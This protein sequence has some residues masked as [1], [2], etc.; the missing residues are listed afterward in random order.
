MPQPVVVKHWAA[1]HAN[2]RFR[3]FSRSLLED[4]ASS[5]ADGLASFLRHRW[6]DFGKV[7]SMP[8]E[9]FISMVQNWDI[10]ITFDTLQ[11]MSQ[12]EESPL[13]NLI[14]NVTKDVITFKSSGDEE[15]TQAPAEPEAA[16]GG[17]GEVGPEIKVAQMAN[18]ALSNRQ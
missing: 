7:G 12:D 14:S 5:V 10:P 15:D 2:M 16:A 13:K 1:K 17:A 11:Q 9:S 8:T 18:R 3:E 6:H 4:E